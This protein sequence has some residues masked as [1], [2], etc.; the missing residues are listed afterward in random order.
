[1]IKKLD[2]APIRIHS[3]PGEGYTYIDAITARADAERPSCITQVY[4]DRPTQY[5]FFPGGR[6]EP[7]E[8]VNLFLTW[9]TR[10]LYNPLATS[11]LSI[12][13]ATDGQRFFETGRRRYLVDDGSYRIFNWG[14]EFSSEINSD[15]PVQ[16]YTLCFQPHI[17][18][19]VLRSLITP[20]DQLLD[21]PQGHREGMPLYFLEKAYP[22]DGFVSPILRHSLTMPLRGI[23]Q[24]VGR[25]DKRAQY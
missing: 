8:P 15:T 4:S 22:H 18:E 14:S 6:V 12:R 3:N 21:A 9:K 2:T 17:A 13:W 7:H 1:M 10:R 5:R 24:L 16:S 19:D 11:T 23:Q 25:R 20:A